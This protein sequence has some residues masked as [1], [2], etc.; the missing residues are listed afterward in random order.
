MNNIN[1]FIDRYVAVWNE[2]EFTLRGANV[3]AMTSSQSI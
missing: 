2:P 3:L 1:E